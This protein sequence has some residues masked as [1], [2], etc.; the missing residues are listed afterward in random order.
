MSSS[1]DQQR[2]SAAWD[3]GAGPRNYLMLVM[4]QVIS[5]LAALSTIWLLTRLLGASGYGAEPI[6]FTTL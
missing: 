4:T 6:P 3:I 1:H 5:S 2:R